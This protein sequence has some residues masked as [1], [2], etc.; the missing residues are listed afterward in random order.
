M[1]AIGQ[2]RAA[3]S[4]ARL[5]E[6]RPGEWGP[7]PPS[8][9]EEPAAATQRPGRRRQRP[10]QAGTAAPRGGRGTRDGWWASG[11]S[12]RPEGGAGD[13]GKRMGVRPG[14]A[15]ERPCAGEGRLGGGRE[16]TRPGP[17]WRAFVPLDN[18]F[19]VSRGHRGSNYPIRGKGV[20]EVWGVWSLHLQSG[21]E[22]SE[23]FKA[24]KKGFEEARGIWYLTPRVVWRGSRGN[25]KT[26]VTKR[27]PGQ[28]YTVMLSV[29]LRPYPVLRMTVPN[30]C[31][32]CRWAL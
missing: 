17:A 29:P 10:R 14:E 23:S 19:L 13:R 27:N 30:F 7:K 4:S 21:R 8:D 22:S 18:P 12:Q 6:G 32:F 1:C 9:S 5:G 31:K 25:A 15:G 26:V 24:E 11:T 16:G 2:A 3:L 20:E 28:F